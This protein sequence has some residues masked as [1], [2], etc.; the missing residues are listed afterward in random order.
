MENTVKTD[1]LSIFESSTLGW[2]T[3]LSC[4]ENLIKALEKEFP[5]NPATLAEKVY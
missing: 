4:K 3:R 1:I 5:E 2:Q